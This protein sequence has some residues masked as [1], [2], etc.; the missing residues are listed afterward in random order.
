MSTCL[1]DAQWHAEGDVLTHVEMVCRELIALPSWRALPPLE[2]NIVFAAALLHDVAKPRLTK[3]ED[4]RPR[5]RGHSLA[6]MRQAR[7]ILA[8]DPCFGTDGT[9]FHVREQVCALVR[10][11]GLPGTLLER[12]DSE[13]VIIAAAMTAR[14]DLVAIL[15]EADTRG[16]ICPGLDQA[17]ERVRLFREFAE[18]CQCLDGPYPFASAA[19]RFRYF[20]TAGEPPTIDVYDASRLTATIMCGLPAAGKDTWVKNNAGANP[21]ISLDEL[22]TELRVDPADDQG[23]VIRAAKE[24]AK[25]YLRASRSFIWNATNTTRML[26][27]GLI[28]LFTA[29]H[30]KVRIV[31]CDAP[32]VD[33]RHRNWARDMPVPPHVIEKLM[34]HLDIPDLTEAHDVVN[35][36]LKG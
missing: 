3:E 7:R 18:E 1:Q 14:C 36:S 22:R 9:P 19:S 6:G 2:R 5:S 35:V 16:R 24:A 31:N 34:D 11:H 15:A 8:E 33:I 10:Y 32:L 28:D 21:V 13:R 30:A 20:H 4:G 25:T 26:R 27:E 17:I 29:Y 12:V 23:P